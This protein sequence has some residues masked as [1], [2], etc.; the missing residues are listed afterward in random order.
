MKGELLQGRRIDNFP[1]KRLMHRIACTIQSEIAFGY[2]IDNSEQE[3][4]LKK[5]S[6]ASLGE[7]PQ[8]LSLRHD[9]QMTATG[10]LLTLM[11]LANTSQQLLMTDSRCSYSGCFDFSQ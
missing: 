11:S 7:T 2:D 4:C 9:Q 3:I 5:I 10:R 6:K 8:G 1:E